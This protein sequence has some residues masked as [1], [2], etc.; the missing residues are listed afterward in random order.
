MNEQV[1]EWL[2]TYDLGPTNILAYAFQIADNTKGKANSLWSAG[3]VYAQEISILQLPHNMIF[4]KDL[5]TSL[6]DPVKEGVAGPVLFRAN[7]KS[8]GGQTTVDISTCRTMGANGQLQ[9]VKSF[10]S[11][12]VD[13]NN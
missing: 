6:Q 12:K 11:G 5:P 10:K 13:T 3:D 2:A 4:G 9:V 1:N 8:V 7:G